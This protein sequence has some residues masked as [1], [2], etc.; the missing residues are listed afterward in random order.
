MQDDESFVIEIWLLK[1]FTWLSF[2]IWV[3]FFSILGKIQPLACSK[4]EKDAKEVLEGDNKTCNNVSKKEMFEFHNSKWWYDNLKKYSEY[5]LTW[6]EIEK[7][8]WKQP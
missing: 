2:I 8:E 6:S 4:Q 1:N 7:V 3:K 5:F